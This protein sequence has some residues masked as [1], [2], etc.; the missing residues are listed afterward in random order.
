V[1]D[2]ERTTAAER[3]AAYRQCFTKIVLN[4]EAN[5]LT[6]HWMPAL[7]RLRGRESEEVAL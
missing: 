6:V 2:P 4:L 7:A 3:N 1:L 5:T